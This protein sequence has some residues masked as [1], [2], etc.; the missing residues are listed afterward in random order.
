MRM[1][2]PTTGGCTETTDQRHLAWPA[3]VFGRT[4]YLPSRPAD[5]AA[6][7]QTGTFIDNYKGTHLF[8]DRTRRRTMS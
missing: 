3:R 2:D 7:S 4:D 5:M 1:V 6:L 8:G